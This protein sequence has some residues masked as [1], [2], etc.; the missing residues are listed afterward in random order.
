LK[1]A[2]INKHWSN[3]HNNNGSQQRCISFAFKAVARIAGIPECRALVDC[4][5][6]LHFPCHMNYEHKMIKIQIE[7]L[8]RHF[9]C[10]IL[11]ACCNF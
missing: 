6:N 3:N 9:I 1:A 8:A 4:A 5:I 7:M 11:P 10:A 2:P